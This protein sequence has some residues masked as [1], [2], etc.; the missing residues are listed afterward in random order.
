MAPWNTYGTVKPSGILPSDGMFTEGELM[1]PEDK[2]TMT[3][4]GTRG[5]TRCINA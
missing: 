5:G 2:L 1:F 4:E 3:D